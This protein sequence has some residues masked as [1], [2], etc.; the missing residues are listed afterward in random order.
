MIYLYIYTSPHISLGLFC[1]II[2]LDITHTVSVNTRRSCLSQ[3]GLHGYVL[4]S[5]S[6]EERPA[7]DIEGT[8][9]APTCIFMLRH[10]VLPLAFSDSVMTIMGKYKTR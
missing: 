4:S 8:P 3:C 6:W 9:L 7:A 2:L 1:H 5:E 10:S